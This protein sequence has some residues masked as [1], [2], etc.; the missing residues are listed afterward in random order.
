MLR[1]FSGDKKIK[2]YIANGSTTNIWCRVAGDKMLKVQGER[3]GGVD[4]HTIGVNL[5]KAEKFQHIAGATRG[6]SQIQLGNTLQF[7]PSTSSNSVYMTIINAYGSTICKNHEIGRS[8]NYIIDRRDALLDAK[9]KKMWIDANGCDHML[10]YVVDD[11]YG[12]DTPECGD[13]KHNRRGALLDA[14]KKEMWKDD[15]NFR[16]YFYDEDKKY[17]RDLVHPHNKFSAQC[18]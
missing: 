17:S 7:E 11:E 13:I 6:Y 10:T 4:V 8:R 14:K 2:V 5:H 18:W 12:F 1:C 3:G 15:N 9:K 16:D